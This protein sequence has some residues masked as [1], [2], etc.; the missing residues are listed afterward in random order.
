MEQPHWKSDDRWGWMAAGSLCLV[1]PLMVLPEGFDYSRL[2]AGSAANIGAEG[3]GTLL[4][5]FCW[6]TALGTSSALLIWR[7]ALAQRLLLQLNPWFLVL[8]VLAALSFGWS[9][10]PALTARRMVRVLTLTCC[11][12]AFVCTGW[13]ERRLQALFRPLLTSLLLGSLAFGLVWPE[14]AIHSETSPELVGAWRGLTSHKNA[15]GGLAALGCLFWFHAGVSRESSRR[16]STMGFCVALLCLLLSRSTTSLLAT[17]CTCSVLFVFLPAAAPRRR[18]LPWFATPVLALS[19]LLGLASVS[20]LPGL[21]L[22]SAPI[23]LL[24]GKDGTLTG[25][26]AIWEIVR[27]HIAMRPLFGSGYG[28]YWQPNRGRGTESAVFVQR[29]AG[30]YPGS[31]HNGYLDVTNDLGGAGLAALA[32]YLITHVRRALRCSTQDWHQSLLCLAVWLQQA[33]T[34]LSESHWFNVT[35]VDF[36]FLSATTFTLARLQMQQQ[37]RA[38]YGPLPAQPA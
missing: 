26:T 16:K 28:A 37:F 22:V 5:H 27:E 3:S 14:F 2:T 13:H 38:L 24:A 34:N 36:V 20:S 25:R 35:S 10:D 33:I 6:M 17:L 4:S 19:L 12:L 7:A 1:V 9:I 11:L 29:L 21:G 18:W 15:L 31:A 23:A 32:A 30:F 8:L